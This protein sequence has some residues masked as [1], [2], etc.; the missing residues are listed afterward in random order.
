MVPPV[1]FINPSIEPLKN[2]K[3]VLEMIGVEMG[4]L[5]WMSGYTLEVRI[6]TN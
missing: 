2:E 5:Q 3:Y 1:C 4:M 6:R